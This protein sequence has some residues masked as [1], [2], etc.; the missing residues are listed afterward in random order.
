[1]DHFKINTEGVD[2]VEY[3]PDMRKGVAGETTLF[4]DGAIQVRIGNEAFDGSFG[5]LGSTIGHEVEVHARHHMAPGATSSTIAGQEVEALSWEIKQQDR[6]GLTTND[7][8]GLN[9]KKG[10]FEGLLNNQLSNENTMK[11][12]LNRRLE[13]S[14]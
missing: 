4:D 11:S 1:M 14:Y 13:G 12:D 10:Y 3:S 7:I 8:Q 2:T 5:Q 6:F 9:S